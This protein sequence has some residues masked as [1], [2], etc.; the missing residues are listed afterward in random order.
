M[1]A[2]D[3]ITNFREG[4][5]KVRIEIHTLSTNKAKPRHKRITSDRNAGTLK[6]KIRIR[7]SLDPSTA[8]FRQET[9]WGTMPI[10]RSKIHLNANRVKDANMLTR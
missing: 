5:G 2:T 7:Y 8:R 4:R 1:R 10:T 3:V 9:C 6:L